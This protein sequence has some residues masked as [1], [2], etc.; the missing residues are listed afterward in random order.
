VFSIREICV[1]FSS[2]D[3]LTSNGSS[4]DV[5]AGPH[6]SPS[7]RL[8]GY[9]WVS[10]ARQRPFALGLACN[11]LVASDNTEQASRELERLSTYAQHVILPVSSR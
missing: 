6:K 5:S 3:T 9:S 10:L 7:L 8:G 11:P 2:P 4:A 1:V